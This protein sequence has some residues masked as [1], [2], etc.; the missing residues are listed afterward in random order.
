[1]KKSIILIAL[2]MLVGSAFAQLKKDRN[3]AYNYWMKKDLVKAKEYIDKAVAY[4]EA[5]SD[6][7]VWYYR[8]GIYLDI[9]TSEAKALL[10]PNAIDVSLESFNKAKELDTKGEYTQD[11]TSRMLTIAGQYFNEGIGN[12]QKSDVEGALPNFEKAIAIS[13]SFHAID[14][15]AVYGAALC[16]EKKSVTDKAFLDKAIEKYKYLVDIKMKEPGVYASLA[17]L[18]KD[19]NDLDKATEALK[20]GQ[21]LY[22]GNTDLIIAEANLYISTNNHAKAVSSLLAAKEKEPKNVSVLY[23]V[24]VTYDL[25]KNDSKLPAE[26]RAKYF[27]EAVK[28]YEETIAVDANFFDA[29]FNLGAMYF[30]KGGDL[31]NE[32]NRLPINETAKYDAM[33]VDGNNYLKKALPYLEKCQQLQPEDKATLGS[34]KE[35]YT[36][37]NMQDKLQEVKTKLGQ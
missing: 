35:I 24:G 7:K 37:L 8:G 19:K 16:L 21:A 25:M 13:E 9:Q 30:N 22:P 26:E 11:I 27:E 23:A 28:G 31:I 33:I 17:N 36:R 1:M 3:S 5:A 18:Y 10:A 34:L 4:P 12:F 20:A 32:A 29:I 14:T 6:A 15:M 2:V